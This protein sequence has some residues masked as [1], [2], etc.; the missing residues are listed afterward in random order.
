MIN[1]AKLM[2]TVSADILLGAIFSSYSILNINQSAVKDPAAEQEK[3]VISTWKLPNL[4][5]GLTCS[6]RFGKIT[7]PRTTQVGA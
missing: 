2:K 4:S 3:N 6:S 7:R 1:Q 5:E